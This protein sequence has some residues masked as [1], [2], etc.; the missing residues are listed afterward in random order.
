MSVPRMVP[1]ILASTNCFTNRPNLT[2]YD[3]DGAS[4]VKTRERLNMGSCLGDLLE[5]KFIRHPKTFE[6]LRPRKP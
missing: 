3:N 5:K 6:N 4:S 1:E 2:K